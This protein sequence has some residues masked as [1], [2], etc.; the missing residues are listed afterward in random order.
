M[1]KPKANSEA[2]T[3]NMKFIVRAVAKCQDCTRVIVHAEAILLPTI[4]EPQSIPL[5]KSEEE[6]MGEK[7]GNGIAAALQTVIPGVRQL[8]R[9]IGCGNG[10][11]SLNFNFSAEEYDVLGRPTVGDILKT[12][13]E[14]TKE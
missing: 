11:P 4:N 14:L 5:A 9:S 8:N 13:V 6:K 10:C 12:S 1:G 7:L 3:V 2:A